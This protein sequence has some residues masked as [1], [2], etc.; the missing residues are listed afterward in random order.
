M[1]LPDPGPFCFGRER[2]QGEDSDSIVSQPFRPSHV[3]FVELVRPL[4]L[5]ELL[6]SPREVDRD[7]PLVVLVAELAEHAQALL[8]RLRCRLPIGRFDGCESEQE[9]GVRDAPRIAD[10]LGERQGVVDPAMRGLELPVQYGHGSR[11]TQRFGAR[12]RR[13]LVRGE[14][15]LHSSPTL[16]PEATEVPETGRRCGEAQKQLR[17]TSL[18]QP[19]ERGSQVVAIGVEPVDPFGVGLPEMRLCFLRQAQE[20][21]G[22]PAADILVDSFR[23]ELANGLEHPVAVA[24]VA[25]RGSCPRAT[26]ARRRRLRHVFG[27]LERAAAAKDA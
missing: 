13:R 18:L 3:L 16:G 25:E 15:A 22:V 5:T 6:V 9:P 14:R 1:H 11:L 27:R 20:V 26:A 7:H 2:R 12:G 10:G 23:C 8:E 4:E 24:G 17:L 21:L 19:V